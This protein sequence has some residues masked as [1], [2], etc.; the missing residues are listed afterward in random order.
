VVE[1]YLRVFCNYEQSDWSDLLSLAEFAYNNTLNS[2]TQMTPFFANQGYHPQFST[3]ID[4][5]SPSPAATDRAELI[6]ATLQDLRA[7]LSHAQESYAA[8]ANASRRPHNFQVGDLVFLNRKNIRTTRPARKL[9]D[10]FFGPFKIT[11][12]INDVSFRLSLPSSL[13]I[14]PVFHVSLFKPKNPD[15][16]DMPQPPPPEPI[17]V[18][19]DLEY[20]VEAILDSKRFRRTVKYLVHWKGYDLHDRTWEPFSQLTNCPDKI[21]EFHRR[22]PKKPRAR[23]FRDEILKEGDDVTIT[24][25]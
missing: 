23:E 14:H 12:R 17:T 3:L 8:F 4:K 19:D 2:T 13:K 7:N 25:Q 1:Q 24:P 6:D 18:D 9:D 11:D 21:S 10:K 20:E 22:N 16:L 15:R 5:R